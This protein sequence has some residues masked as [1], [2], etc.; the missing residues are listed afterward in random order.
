MGKSLV[1]FLV[2][3]ILAT[4][5]LVRMTSAVPAQTRESVRR[6]VMTS[7]AEN[8]VVMFGGI[9]GTYREDEDF[10][11][12]LIPRLEDDGFTYLAM[13][14]ERRPRRDSLHEVIQDYA[15][16]R[17]TREGMRTMWIK[18]EQRICAGTFDLIDAAKRAGMK[19]VF[20]DADENRYK[21]WRD[22]ERIAFRHLE[23]M[24]FT[25]DP[26]AKVVV[27]CGAWHI[28]KEPH[29]D[30]S[31]DLRRGPA[32]SI[33]Y[34]AYYIGELFKNRTFTVSLLG[35]LYAEII[36]PYCDLVLDLEENAYY[37]RKTSVSRNPLLSEADHVPDRLPDVAGEEKNGATKSNLNPGAN[38][39]NLFLR[40]PL[41]PKGGGL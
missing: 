19:V 3:N 17:L 21:S 10:V 36:T 15:S 39:V 12:E 7:A 18:R 40:E 34:L 30:A 6:V 28:N 14:F 2:I 16:G 37:Y 9:H 25:K 31:A 33:K 23:Q 22:R 26:I 4:G 11:A 20:Y 27:F 1:C 38:S 5:G 24:V 41:E 29:D 8:R 13:E 32:G 35:P